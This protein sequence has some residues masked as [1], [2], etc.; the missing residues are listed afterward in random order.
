M[1]KFILPFVLFNIFLSAVPSFAF[2]QQSSNTIDLGKIIIS[3][4]RQE[5][6]IDDVSDNVVVYTSKDIAALPAKDLGEILQYIPGVNG[7]VKAAFG[8]ATAVTIHGS[9]ARHVLIMVDGIPFNTQLSGQANPTVIPKFLIE[10]IEVIKGAGSHAWGS[11]LGG[12]INVITKSLD[13]VEEPEIAFSSL[14]SEYQTTENTITVAGAKQGLQYYIGGSFFDTKGIKTKS[15]VTRKEFYSKLV[16]A[17]TDQ[18]KL[19]GSFGYSGSR[20]LEEDVPGDFWISQPIASHFGQLNYEF[21]DE[22]NKGSMAYKFNKQKITT[23][24]YLNPATHFSATISTDLYHGLSFNKQWT[25]DKDLLN[26]GLDLDWHELKSNNYL[27]K[28]RGISMQAPFI[29]YTKNWDKWSLNTGLRYD[30]NAQFGQQ[31]SPSIG[32]VFHLRKESNTL[33]RWK[34]ARAFSAPP[35]LWMYNEDVTYSIGAN[36]DLKAERAMVYDLGF[37]SKVGE[38]FHFEWDVY[39][40]QVKDAIATRSSGSLWIKD[41]YQE[42]KKQGTELILDY[43]LFPQVKLYASAEFNNVIDKET[44]KKVRDSSILRNGYSFGVKYGAGKGL[45]L[46]LM[47][48]YNRWMAPASYGKNDGKVIVNFK[49]TKDFELPRYHQKCQLFFNIYNLSDSK[50]W[51]DPS[52][53]TASR[54]FEGGFSV[55]F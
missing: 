13:E 19:T 24:Y 26:V 44:N 54:Y 50:Y 23:D 39:Y 25:I 7:S 38:K 28:S 37:E 41:N 33:F 18:S 30:H 14:V 36:P 5:Q 53:P 29:N 48:E 34:A 45:L 9:E 47:G 55:K 40:S 21:E 1:K 20:A 17:L 22:N 15:S 32:G 46:H 35:L 27:S 4:Y 6:S 51:T 12:V 11:A 2:I 10:R 52:Y 16:Y 43:D 42:F 31:L 8:Q 3:A 49:A